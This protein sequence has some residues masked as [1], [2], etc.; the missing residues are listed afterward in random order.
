MSNN[1]EQ[2]KPSVY[3]LGAADGLWVGLSMGA[4]VFCMIMASRWP[5]LALVGLALFIGTPALAW[6]F[7][8]RAWISRQV[9]ASFSAVWLHGICIFLF[10]GILMALVMYVSLRFLAPGWIET[11]TL[12]TAERMAADP[13]TS[14]QARLLTRIVETGNLPS[15]IYTSVSAIWLVA[16]T[17]SMWSMLFAFILTRF[18]LYRKL[19][20]T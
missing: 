9:P 8:R 2:R 3:S 15:D 14:E 11:Q 16:F 10:G 20:L 19:R 7:L 18:A 5:A 12:L 4:C 1:E 17:G 6:Y 13:E